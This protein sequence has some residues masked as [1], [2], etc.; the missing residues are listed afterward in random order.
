[1]PNYN[2]QSGKL[3]H[4][5]LWAYI[6][7]LIF[8]GAFRKWFLPGLSDV[9]LLSR[10]PIVFLIYL[11]ALQSRLF[12]MNFFVV[13]TGILM[14]VTGFL[15]YFIHGNLLTL[16]YGI[17]SNFFF[18]PLIFLFPKV[19]DWGDVQRVGKF[20][21]LVAIPMTVLIGMQFYMPQSA[22][23]N[24]S[25]GGVEGAGFT[26]ALGRYRPP[27]TFS[28]IT[29]V[30]QFFTLFFAFFL[31]QFMHKRTIS[32]PLLLVCGACVPLAVFGS[33]S[34]LLALSVLVV[35]IMGVFALFYN[36]RRLPNSFKV[37]AAMVLCTALASQLPFF[38]DATDA[39]S[40]RWERAT[41]ED[42][43]GFR[44][45]II[46]RTIGELTRPF[47]GMDKLPFWGMGLGT[48]TQAGAQLMTGQRGFQIAEGE[49]GRV[50]GELGP[51]LGT[52]FILLRL[53]LVLF[54]GKI[55]L[56]Q[57]LRG[58]FLPWLM[59]SASF[60]LILYGQWGQQTSIGFA[61]LGAGLTLSACRTSAY[62]A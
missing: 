17:L 11:L 25:V 26:G 49:W 40:A 52:L 14:V 62:N 61:I 2:I 24:R 18:I 59:F 3:I 47:A 15:A 43:G 42:R 8:D 60:L 19:W 13:L 9:F 29:G 56:D 22:W 55:A 28:F 35:F 32:M 34:R 6:V 23:V 53:G 1:M 20:F 58:N 4:Y 50:M 12:P 46:A 36:G 44:Q 33:I 31:H 54:L 39:F 7:A 16:G 10:V 5:L 51:V 41:G 27:G 38:Q 57:V 30:A 37:L 48:G 21:L 45:A